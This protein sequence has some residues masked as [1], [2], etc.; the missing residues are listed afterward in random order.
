V[1]MLGRMNVRLL[2]SNGYKW[3]CSLFLGNKWF[4]TVGDF[5]NEEEAVRE[6]KAIAARWNAIEL[7][8]DL[9][10]EPQ[11]DDHDAV[12]ASLRAEQIVRRAIN[13]EG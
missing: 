8:G 10:A 11:V 6:A 1:T 5:D 13:G 4:A 12:D 3:N 7:L 2:D 9:F